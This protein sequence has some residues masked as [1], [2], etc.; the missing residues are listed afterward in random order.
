MEFTGLE[1]GLLFTVIAVF[2]AASVLSAGVVSG[3]R[4]GRGLRGMLLAG[5]GVLTA[6]LIALWIREGQIPLVNR[7][8][9]TIFGAWILAVGAALVDR[10]INHP[11]LVLV[12][13]P[14]VCLLCLF[15]WLIALRPG[16]AG[17]DTIHPGVFVHILLAV[18]GLAAFTF[19]AGIGAYYLWQ[20]RQ[21]KRDPASA[22]HQKVLP[23]EVLD[24]LNFGAAAVGFPL[25]MMSVVGATLFSSRARGDV[26]GLLLD[27]T[28]LV[29]VGGLFVY[30]M[31]FGARGIFGWRGRRIA[32]LSVAGFLVI[33]L[34]MLVAAF[35]T[36]PNLFHST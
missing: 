3:A 29:T 6:L 19:A 36:S 18:I 16:D 26:R 22:L 2:A 10:R 27:P 11:A 12:S 20:I 17:P 33:S 8:E 23:L 25:L 30:M 1:Q 7:A 35:C 15:G 31:L 32:W 4:R 14:M 28:V 34:G 13:A 9:Y 5:T 24:Q 21:L